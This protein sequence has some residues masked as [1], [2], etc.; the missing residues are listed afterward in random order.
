[1]KMETT[2]ATLPRI[3]WNAETE[4]CLFYA[5][6][7]QKPIGLNKHFHMM[8]IHKKFCQSLGQ[9][10]SSDQLWEHLATMYNLRALDDSEASPFKNTQKEFKL[11]A[12]IL[13]YNRDQVKTVE[14]FPE[15]EDEELPVV[16]NKGKGSRK[17]TR[18]TNTNS[19]SS[20]NVVK[21]RR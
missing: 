16:S 9:T 20:P 1:M 3:N 21:R 14:D 7:G 8:C 10:V 11:P 18:H 15:L 5:M 2:C 17:R 6:R 13:N 12:S 4:V 19:P